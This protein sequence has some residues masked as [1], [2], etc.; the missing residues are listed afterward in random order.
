MAEWTGLVSF[1]TAILLSF[2]DLRFSVIPLAGFVLL[3]LVAPFLPF[4]GYYLPI[5]SRGKSG[6]QAVALTFDDGPDPLSTPDLL[7][8]LAKHQ[9]KAT[10]FVIGEKASE[11]PELVRE[12][13]RQ[14][15]SIGN[16]T[17]THDNLML[18]KNR[19]HLLNEIEKTQNVL[20]ELGVIS[21]AFRP[22]VGITS[23]GLIQILR[24]L[25][26]YTVN[27]SC[28]AF[29][30]GNRRI[31]NLSKKILIRVH[32]DDIL[33]LHDARPKNDHLFSYWLQEMDRILTGIEVKGLTVL[34]LSAIIG[35]SVMGKP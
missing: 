33:L 16:H 2:V 1:L 28:R 23:P 34:P 6:E 9:V 10:F 14:G 4:L 35:R 29:D 11:H 8:L 7:R 25:N 18:L 12:I 26:L 30:C 22:P 27:F 17:Y 31:R 13:V 5:I 3:C 24:H 20:R 15:H 32:P 21:Y 19:H